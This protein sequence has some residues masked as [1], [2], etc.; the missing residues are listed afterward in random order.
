MDLDDSKASWQ[1]VEHMNFTHHLLYVHIHDASLLS[2]RHKPRRQLVPP[3]TTACCWKLSTG[4]TRKEL[5]LESSKEKF[6]IFACEW[7]QVSFDNSTSWDVLTI[8]LKHLQLSFFYSTIKHCNCRLEYQY[9]CRDCLRMCA[10]FRGCSESSDSTIG[11]FP[12][13]NMSRSWCET[14]SFR[15]H[16]G[17]KFFNVQNRLFCY[18]NKRKGSDWLGGKM[19]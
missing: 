7:R 2:K 12:D 8:T 4:K 13:V 10:F 11:N 1:L 15:C 18:F 14:D 6:C 9:F 17:T 5:L 16:A 19:G 3:Q